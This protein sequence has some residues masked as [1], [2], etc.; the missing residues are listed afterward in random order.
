MYEETSRTSHRRES[1]KQFV[2][3][4]ADTLRE[5]S[6][7]SAQFAHDRFYESDYVRKVEIIDGSVR[8][9][10]LQVETHACLFA[11]GILAHN[12]GIIDDPTKN[13]QEALSEVIQERNR[14][15]YDSVF[16]TRLQE[17]SGQVIIGTPWSANDLLAH[18]RRQSVDKP[19]FRLLSFPALNYPDEI[20]YRDDLPHGAL[21]PKLHSETQLREIKS[22]MGEMWWAALYQQTPLADAGAIFK[23]QYVQ[24]YRQADLPKQWKRIIISVDATFKDHK[25]ADYVCVGAWG[26]AVD[27][28]T[29]LL[30]WRREKLAFTATATAIIDLKNKYPRASRIYIEDA[31]NGP[32]LIDMLSKKITGIEAVPP[33]GSKEARWHAVSWVWENRLVWL[34]DPTEKLGIAPVVSEITSVPDSLTGHDD[35]ADMMAIALHQLHLRSPIAAMITKEILDRARG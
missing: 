17:H 4:F 6:P 2:L 22:H 10:D 20:G 33:L 24:Y 21:V 9:F 25:K 35:A 23:K 31:A 3:Q 5:L 32:A 27:D 34:P 29:Y 18:I 30:D 1:Y 7:P 28:S 26:Q 8:V 11:N 19:N 12:C 14:D 15:W 16:L 13:A